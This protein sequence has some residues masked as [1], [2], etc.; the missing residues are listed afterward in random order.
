VRIKEEDSMILELN[1][2]FNVKSIEKIQTVLIKIAILYKPEW[3]KGKT[4]IQYLSR[5]K[6]NLIADVNAKKFLLSGTTLK[7]KADTIC[8][9]VEK[10]NGKWAMDDL[11]LYLEDQNDIMYYSLFTMQK[12]TQVSDATC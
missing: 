4:R 11:Y 5:Y 1:D 8:M 9:I 7:E 6:L 12:P 10:F 2:F 3:L